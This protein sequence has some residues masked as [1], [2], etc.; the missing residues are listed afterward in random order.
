MRRLPAILVALGVLAAGGCGGDPDEVRLGEGADTTAGGPAPGQ[1]PEERV[2]R[3]WNEAVNLGDYDRAAGFFAQGALVEQLAATR[4]RTREDA[5][6]FNRGLPCRADVTD[7]EGDG[8]STIAAFRL[9]EGRTGQCDEGG[10]ARV[11]F[12]IRDGKIREWRQLPPS[13]AAPGEVAT[14]RRWVL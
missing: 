7:L 8:G 6:D 4:L 14:V 5:I 12:V 3:G 13:Q 2:I 9:R 10:S 11:R 1:S